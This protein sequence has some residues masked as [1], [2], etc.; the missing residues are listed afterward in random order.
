MEIIIF[1]FFEAYTFF[2]WL[3]PCWN[4]FFVNINRYIDNF[5]SILLSD[6]IYIYFPWVILLKLSKWGSVGGKFYVSVLCQTFEKWKQI[7][8]SICLSDG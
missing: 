2:L 4:P 3:L 1:E 6:D 7:C 8:L 5:S